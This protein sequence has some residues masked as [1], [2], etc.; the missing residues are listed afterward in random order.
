MKLRTGTCLLLHNQS[1]G[2]VENALR[3]V[4]VLE[5]KHRVQPPG[6]VIK[7][8]RDSLAVQPVVL[9]EAQNRGLIGHGVIDVVLLRVGLDHQQRQTRTIRNVPG[10]ALWSHPQECQ[11]QFRIG[12]FQ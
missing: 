12:P 1:G 3:G 10:H 7:R 5:I 6:K 9:D 11:F 8:S 2:R 4:G